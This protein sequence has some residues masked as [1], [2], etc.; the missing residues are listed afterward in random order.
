MG[1]LDGRVALITGGARGQGRS[2]ALAL[3]GEGAAIVVCDIAAETLNTVPY[4]LGTAEQL[5][6]TV[7]LVEDLDQRAIAVPGDVA[8]SAAMAKVVDA[9]L[10]EFGRI[11]VMCANAGIFTFG[12]IVDLPDEKWDEVVAVNL[13]GV[14]KSVR[15]VLPHMVERG[16]GSIIATASLA[17]KSG[18][19]NCG[20][21]A[22]TKWGVIGLIKSVALEVASKGVRAN[23]VCP[24]TVNTQMIHNDDLNRLFCPGLESP[25]FEDASRV[26]KTNSP[27]RVA[28][29]EPSD[30]SDAVVFLAS[31][32]SRYITGE[33]IS[34]GAGWSAHNAA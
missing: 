14:F 2:H 3:A 28:Y 6:E 5:A 22:A 10:S 4:P 26:M 31:D 12:P 18:F 16:T 30:I 24:T 11:D 27:M 21:Y 8:D 32:E 25:T 33:T 1:R 15:A 7:R 19:P 9:A 23:V 20:H 29:V 17:G 34:V 13:T